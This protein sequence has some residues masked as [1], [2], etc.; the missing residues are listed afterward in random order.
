[1]LC[2]VTIKLLTTGS[3]PIALHRSYTSPCLPKL[4][5]RVRSSRTLWCLPLTSLD[6]PLVYYLLAVHFQILS[7]DFHPH[8][9]HLIIPLPPDGCV[10]ETACV[11]WM[12][13]TPNDLREKEASTSVPAQ[14]VSRSLESSNK[15]SHFLGW[16]GPLH[17]TFFIALLLIK[18]CLKMIYIV[19]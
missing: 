19:S 17:V 18:S 13:D 4:T 9:D 10:P 14:K 15:S 6:S 2:C 8:N 11:Q 3:S 16:E 5:M 12:V 7:I 1:M